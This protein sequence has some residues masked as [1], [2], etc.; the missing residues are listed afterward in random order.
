M[1]ML[2]RRQFTITRATGCKM[3][4]GRIQSH[5]E[6]ARS[7]M[8]RAEMYAVLDSVNHTTHAFDEQCPKR[9]RL[10]IANNP[11]RPSE[12]PRW[13]LARMYVPAKCC[14]GRGQTSVLC[15]STTM[16]SGPTVAAVEIEEKKSLAIRPSNNSHSSCLL[17]GVS[18]ARP[19]SVLI[20]TSGLWPLGPWSL[21]A[22]D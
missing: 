11:S 4:L 8:R 18:R 19:A 12:A 13:M 15:R 3:E 21:L 9:Y 6:L 22:T 10:A 20:E 14:S 5:C 17:H 16:M 7:R 2:P 1:S